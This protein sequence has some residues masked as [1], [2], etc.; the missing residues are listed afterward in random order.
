MLGA[1]HPEAGSGQTSV[2]I[3][4]AG[5]ARV[6]PFWRNR[7]ERHS[8]QPR[9]NAGMGVRGAG[10]RWDRGTRLHRTPLLGGDGSS[11]RAVESRKLSPFRD[12]L[13]V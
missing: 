11:I 5:A 3:G 7:S 4:A 9:G 12:A 6:D 2:N 1:N 10:L 13:S 8:H